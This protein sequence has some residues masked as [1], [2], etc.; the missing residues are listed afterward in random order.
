MQTPGFWWL[1]F[2]N[3]HTAASLQRF[4][5]WWVPYGQRPLQRSP[6]WRKPSLVL[7]SWTS[8]EAATG[9]DVDTDGP[10]ACK[11]WVLQDVTMLG[12]ERPL[13]C[14]TENIQD[15][16]EAHW[17]TGQG[18]VTLSPIGCLPG[19]CLSPVPLTQRCFS[20]ALSELWW[21]Q[22]YSTS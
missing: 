14:W 8:Y 21:L 1:S 17:W 9:L 10:S 13:A 22:G 6:G 7:A 4:D 19:D 16:Q 3:T 2:W 20:P 15:I 5:M 18:T 12:R 11:V